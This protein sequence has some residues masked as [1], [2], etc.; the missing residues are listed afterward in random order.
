MK[1]GWKGIQ[2]QEKMELFSLSCCAEELFYLITKKKKKSFEIWIW[3]KY[4]Y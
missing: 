1:K 2:N 3:F 4:I